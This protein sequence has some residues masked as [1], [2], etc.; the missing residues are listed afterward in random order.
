MA[1]IWITSG[2]WGYVFPSFVSRITKKNIENP[3]YPIPANNPS[4]RTHMIEYNFGRMKPYRISSGGYPTGL[5]EHVRTPSSVW[6]HT[7][8]RTL[9]GAPWREEIRFFGRTKGG[10]TSY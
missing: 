5:E 3:F 1:S 4:I 6:I 2:P 9:S 7:M 8:I 10:S